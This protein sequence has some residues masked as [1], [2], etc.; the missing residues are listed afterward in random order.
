MPVNADRGLQAPMIALASRSP[1][2][3]ALWWVRDFPGGEDQVRQARHWIEDLLPQ[4]DPLAD[5]LLL[6]S[7]LC[8]NA[9]VHTR[10]GKAG[11]R[12]SV[13]VEWGQETA[14]VVIGDQGSP[15]ALAITAKAQDG[16]WAD[17]HGRGLG[18]GRPGAHDQPPHRRH[19]RCRARDLAATAGLG[20]HR[21]RRARRWDPAARA[22]QPLHLPGLSPL[23]TTHGKGRAS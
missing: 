23:T 6:A 19:P 14:R 8:T 3:P 11:G 21:R 7:E 5:I 17:E 15:T 1:V 9:V 10:S 20:A 16:I 13:D 4:C 22:R 18:T 12:F 2:P